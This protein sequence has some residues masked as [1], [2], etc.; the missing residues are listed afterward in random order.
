L[1]IVSKKTSKDAL[2][3]KTNKIIINQNQDK[4]RKA[5]TSLSSLLTVMLAV[6]WGSANAQTATLEI[7]TDL[8]GYEAYWETT[9]VGDACGVNTILSGGNAAV[10]CANGCLGSGT[11]ASSADPGAYG[12]QAILGPI[13]LGTAP[14]SFDFHEVDAWGDGG[15]VYNFYVD[16]VLQASVTSPNAA[17]CGTVTSCRCARLYG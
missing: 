11:P 13:A 9:P 7:V 10:G 12:N 3:N 8:W 14:I 15:T 4:M 16:G 17:S 1:Y 2:I 6:C 5:L